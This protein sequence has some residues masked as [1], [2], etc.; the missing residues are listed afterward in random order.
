MI[1]DV[2]DNSIQGA[3]DFI[4]KASQAEIHLTI[5]GVSSSFRSSTCQCL[6]NVKGFNY[7]SAINEDDLMKYVFETFDFGFFPVAHDIELD[8]TCDNIKS[9]KAYGSTDA[10]EVDNYNNNFNEKQ[11]TY[12]ISRMKS[13]FPSEISIKN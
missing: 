7:F 11:E 1:T 10:E 5:I 13:I 12:T 6:K 3:N 4:K 2:G 8:I 9:F